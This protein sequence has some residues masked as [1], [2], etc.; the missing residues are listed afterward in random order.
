MTE[1]GEKE[2]KDSCGQ[3]CGG[4]SGDGECVCFKYEACYTSSKIPP[5]SPR[6]Q[7]VTVSHPLPQI[8]QSA[9]CHFYPSTMLL[10]LCR[11]EVMSKEK[12]VCL[13]FVAPFVWNALPSLLYYPTHISRFR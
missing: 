8:Y 9:F 4:G 6:S 12:A 3:L 7:I 2:R 11:K 1:I 10:I 13:L 5:L